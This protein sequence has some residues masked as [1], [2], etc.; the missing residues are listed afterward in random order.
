LAFFA[1]EGT[2]LAVRPPPPAETPTM[3]PA[4]SQSARTLAWMLSLATA[5][6]SGTGLYSDVGPIPGSTER[7]QPRIASAST[8]N[9]NIV[10]SF[11]IPERS[12]VSVIKVRTQSSMSILGIA[13]VGAPTSLDQMD[14]GEHK[15]FLSAAPVR[16][17]ANV[18]RTARPLNTGDPRLEPEDT[19]R[20]AHDYT[21]LVATAKPLSLSDLQDSLADVDLVGPDDGVVLQRVAEAI[22]GHSLGAW[23]ASAVR[24]AQQSTPF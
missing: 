2:Q 15:V 5:C 16:M 3:R 13:P 17:A 4:L 24:L 12:Y 11:A 6:A 18:R 7:L 1:D 10:V 8:A 22:G 9:N 14:A 21:L 19:G 23:A 20:P